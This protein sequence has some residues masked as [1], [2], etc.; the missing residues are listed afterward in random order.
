M[1]VIPQAYDQFPLAGRIH[2]LGV[3]RR[4]DEDPAEIRNAVRCLLADESPRRRAGELARHLADYD[5]ES[6]VRSVV[7]QVLAHTEVSA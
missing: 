5:G 4:V 7:E 1:V 3:G 6:R 2:E